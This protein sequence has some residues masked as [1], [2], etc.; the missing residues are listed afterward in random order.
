METQEKYEQWKAGGSD[1]VAGLQLLREF[2]ARHIANNL[3]RM[4]NSF[5]RLKLET[6][7]AKRAGA[8]V[9]LPPPPQE[10]EIAIVSEEVEQAL[11]K[12]PVEALLAEKSEIFARETHLRNLMHEYEAPE[13]SEE[14][15][16][17]V[18]EIV[19]LNNRRAEIEETISY[20]TQHGKLP[21]RPTPQSE[22]EQLPDIELQKRLANVRSYITKNRNTLETEKDEKKRSR[23]AANLQRY[24]EELKKLESLINQRTNNAKS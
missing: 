23:A 3:Q 15:K 21:P 1:F 2:G 14:R 17:L 7:L 12:D 18:T 16:R 20:Y 5:A 9:P 24:E 4:N 11:P 6:E 22:L 19:A 8:P 13:K 10:Q